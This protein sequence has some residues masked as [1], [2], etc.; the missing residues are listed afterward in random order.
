MEIV[1]NDHIDHIDQSDSTTNIQSQ[2]NEMLKS[3]IDQ[4]SINNDNFGNG[5]FIDKLCEKIIFSHANSTFHSNNKEA[6]LTIRE[7]SISD[8]LAEKLNYS[9]KRGE[10]IGFHT[11]KK[12]LTQ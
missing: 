10:K 2:T 12:T 1:N 3:E 7:E 6:L 9:S 5:R 8:E 4:Q 11:K